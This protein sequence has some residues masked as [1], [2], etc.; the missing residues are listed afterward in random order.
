MIGIGDDVTISGKVAGWESTYINIETG[1]RITTYN[2][3]LPSGER[4]K[5]HEA[6]I[7]SYHP[8]QPIPETDERKG[9]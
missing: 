1:K 6:D 7:K 4:I 8:Y 5:V 2:V 3:I 9:N